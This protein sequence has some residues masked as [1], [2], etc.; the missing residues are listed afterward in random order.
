MAEYFGTG[1]YSAVGWSCRQ[2]EAKMANEKKLRERIER[3]TGSVH[4]FE[5]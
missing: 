5:T 2:I 4:Q 1:S 3:I